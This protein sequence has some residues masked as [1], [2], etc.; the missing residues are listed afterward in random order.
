AVP[1]PTW[2]DKAESTT[3]LSVM[4]DAGNAV[5]MTHSHGGHVGAAVVTEGLGFLHNNHM[6][7]FDPMPGSV[8]SIV[9]GKRQGGSVPLIVTKGGEPVLVIGGAGGTRQVT[10]TVQTIL[11]VLEHGMPVH[12][13]IAAPRFH[14]EAPSVIYVEPGVPEE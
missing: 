9:P 14:S 4:D 5:S 3:H 2:G 8:D 11:N 10:G 1:P 7:L 13:A 12:K 6:K